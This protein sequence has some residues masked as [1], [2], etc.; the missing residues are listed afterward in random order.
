MD[1][2]VEEF[3]ARTPSHSI[4]VVYFRYFPPF[5]S[6][7]RLQIFTDKVDQLYVNRLIILKEKGCAVTTGNSPHWVGHNYSIVTL[8]SVVLRDRSLNLIMTHALL[9]SVEDKS[10]K[11]RKIA[12]IHYR[13]RWRPHREFFNEVLPLVNNPRKSIF[14]PIQGTERAKTTAVPKASWDWSD[15]PI[16]QPSSMG[17]CGAWIRRITLQRWS[18]S[19]FSLPSHVVH[20][21]D[22]FYVLFPQEGG[23]KFKSIYRIL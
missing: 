10:L 18:V 13:I 21:F 2:F 14:N 16:G 17:S 20:F 9:A 6:S 4:S 23:S 8:P 7:N 3:S 19:W 15:T 1:H 22:N 11:R 5:S 12:E